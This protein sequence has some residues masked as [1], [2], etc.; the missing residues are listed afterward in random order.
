MVKNIGQ[1]LETKTDK[2]KIITLYES[3]FKQS[4][5]EAQ[6]KTLEILIWLLTV[7]KTVR[8]EKA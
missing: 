5:T 4:L 3:H 8:I 2:M 1:N 7:Q 6:N